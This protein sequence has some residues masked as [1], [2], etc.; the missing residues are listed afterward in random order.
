MFKIIAFYIKLYV[1]VVILLTCGKYLHVRIFHK[2]GR[3]WPIKLVEPQHILLKCQYQT[4][5]MRAVMYVC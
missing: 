5:K 1:R 4:R 2:G 3:F